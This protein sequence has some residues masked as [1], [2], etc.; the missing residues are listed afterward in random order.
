MQPSEKQLDGPRRLHY[1]LLRYVHN[2]HKIFQAVTNSNMKLIK[3]R[4]EFVHALIGE[5]DQAAPKK[6]RLEELHFLQGIPA[7]EKKQH[8][9]K[10]C[11]ICTKAK[12]RREM[13]Y[14]CAPLCG[15]LF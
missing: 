11:R 3:F 14:F 13:R 5:K 15:R 7:T 10:P 4:E 8:P 12:K 9:T 2:A 6:R 1:I